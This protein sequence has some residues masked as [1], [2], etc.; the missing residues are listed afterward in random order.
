MG[1]WKQG[2]G[3]GAPRSFRIAF[4]AYASGEAA[5]LSRRSPF[6]SVALGVSARSGSIG[7]GHAAGVKAHGDCTPGIPAPVRID[8]NRVSAPVM[9]FLEMREGGG[10]HQHRVW[11]EGARCAFKACV[12]QRPARRQH[13]MGHQPRDA[14]RSFESSGDAVGTTHS[15]AAIGR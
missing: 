12:A 8:G 15:Y 3:A 14:L 9:R 13:A 11:L 4:R 6:Y 10:S 7:I 2:F 5:S 1:E